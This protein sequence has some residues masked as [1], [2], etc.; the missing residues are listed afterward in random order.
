MFEQ[1]AHPQLIAFAKMLVWVLLGERCHV[2]HYSGS[3]YARL[4]ASMIM[5]VGDAP[6]RSTDFVPRSQSKYEV[7]ELLHDTPSFGN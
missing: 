4:V 6:T 1:P 5:V 3:Q 7:N 2:Y